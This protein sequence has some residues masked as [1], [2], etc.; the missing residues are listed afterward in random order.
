MERKLKE[1]IRSYNKNASQYSDYL[2]ER[3]PQYSLTKFISYLL[4]SRIDRIY[5]GAKAK[6]CAA[7][8]GKKRKLSGKDKAK[9]KGGEQKKPLKLLDAGCAG[10]RDT[11]YLME[12]G[13]DVTGIDASASII[14]E[15][16]KR[17][18]KGRFRVMDIS[19][20]KFGKEAFDGIWCI[21]TLS[22]VPEDSALKTLQG[23]CKVLK[24]GGIAF[25]STPEGNAAGMAESP[26]L[27]GARVFVQFYPQQ[28][29]EELLREAG[30]EIISSITERIDNTDYAT[31]FA[32]KR[33]SPPNS[34]KSGKE[35]KPEQK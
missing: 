34:E 33:A 24:E 27:S 16:K 11:A 30:F 2:E 4:K 31:V 1:T 23:F 5:E 18:R 19:E 3:I 15:A 26:E 17:V 21:G 32:R 9:G 35:Q 25:L 6:S 14:K 8:P 13:F 29:L 20:L 12:E 7:K 28:R 10:G 22:H